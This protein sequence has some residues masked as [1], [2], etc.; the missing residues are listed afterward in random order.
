MRQLVFIICLAVLLG[1]ILSPIPPYAPFPHSDQVM[2]LLGFG[3]VSLTARIAFTRAPA[4]LL[5][6]TLLIFAP[7]SEVLQYTL[8]SPFRNFSWLDIL[9]NLTGVVLAAISWWVLTRVYTRWQT[10]KMK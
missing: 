10:R 9:A 8:V 1:G 2:H 7:L 4:W 6:G 5:W 3:A